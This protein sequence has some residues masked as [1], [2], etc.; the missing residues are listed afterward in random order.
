MRL[1]R[2]PAVRRLLSAGLLASLG[3]WAAAPLAAAGGV[4]E[5][6]AAWARAHAAGPVEAAV[7]EALSAAARETA[8]PGAFAQTLV[9]ALAE[10][11]E[12][13]ALADYLREAGA[14]ALL[15]LLVGHLVRSLGT[16]T[17]LFAAAPPSPAAPVASGPRAVT[18]RAIT[19]ARPAVSSAV[20][21]PAAAP[22]PVAV[23]LL[24]AAQP[25]G[26]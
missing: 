22:P 12:G 10:Q 20:Q 24:S 1:L 25:L 2:L 4:T 15:D 16:P 19:A 26:P 13:A 8:D 5:A 17:A 21:A 11:P 7:A 18:P 14:D 23:R 6:Q 3:L 9:A